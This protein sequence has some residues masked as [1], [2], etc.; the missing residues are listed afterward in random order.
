M[1]LRPF[2]VGVCVGVC[3]GVGVG[4]GV[5]VKCAKAKYRL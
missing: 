1:D 4:V 2:K 5:G 3:V